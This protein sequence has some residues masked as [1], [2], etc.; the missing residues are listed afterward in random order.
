MNTTHKFTAVIADDEPLAR[1]KLRLMLGDDPDVEIVQECSTVAQTVDA[2]TH[3]RPA[4]L[5]LD[6]QMPD[7][8]GFEAL[9]HFESAEMPCV[10]FTTAFDRY[11]I[12]AFEAEAFDYLLKPFDQARFRKCL[13]RIKARLT[14]TDRGRSAQTSEML[15][16]LA[17][18][19]TK[20]FVV[21]SEGR[22]VFLNSV[23]IDWIE[24]AS[25]YVRLH[26]GSAAY[27][28]RGTIGETE[29][30]LDGLPFLRIHRS[31]IVNA[32]RIKEVRPC[33]SGEF[34]VTLC[35]GKELPASRTYR[36]KLEPLLLRTL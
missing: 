7:G 26:S 23:E 6:I 12:R 24:A 18:N 27:Q 22:M 35:T 8:E 32:G 19:A 1:E 30:K 31:I 16:S 4:I 5:F 36:R 21:K 9:L 10:V 15:G 14:H 17:A 34:I 13:D 11:A 28:V 2:V 25:N 20:K 3:L 33:N 29:T